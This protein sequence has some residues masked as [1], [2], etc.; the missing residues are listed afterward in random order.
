MKKNLNGVKVIP[1]LVCMIK[2]NGVAIWVIPTI[3]RDLVMSA[4]NLL[5]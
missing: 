4:E 1:V 3:H 2:M 5:T